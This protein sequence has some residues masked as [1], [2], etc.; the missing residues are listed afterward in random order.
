M[1]AD[2]VDF[3]LRAVV[4]LLVHEDSQRVH[5]GEVVCLGEEG[6]EVRLVLGENV[7]VACPV[8]VFVVGFVFFEGA[9]EVFEGD[10]FV[11]SDAVGESD[12]AEAFVVVA[13]LVEAYVDVVHHG[14]DFGCGDGVH[15]GFLFF[16][17]PSVLLDMSNISQCGV[18]MIATRRKFE[19]DYAL[20]A[21]SMR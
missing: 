17:L 6:E 11:G 18:G 3:G 20:T 12:V 13:F 10:E 19:V 8:R 4:V 21:S 1:L 5:S 7:E 9:G 16:V 2:E 15:F 14:S